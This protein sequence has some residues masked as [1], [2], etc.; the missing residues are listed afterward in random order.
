MRAILTA[1]ALVLLAS[2]ALALDLEADGGWSC[3]VGTAL[4]DLVLAGGSYSFTDQAGSKAD[5]TL[6]AYLDGL[7][8]D[9]V[10]GPLADAGVAAINLQDDGNGPYLSLYDEAD[11][12]LA[13][14]FRAAAT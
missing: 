10:T 5:G 1:G 3:Q 14:C 13:T 11:F 4:G 7:T 9:V 12:T 6:A 8:Y 2:P